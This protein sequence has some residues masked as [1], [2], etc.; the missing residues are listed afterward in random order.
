MKD[1]PAYLLKNGFVDKSIQRAVSC[2]T[3]YD[4]WLTERNIA[5]AEANYSDLLN[6]I[7]HMQQIGKSKSTINENLRYI[8]VYYN[9]L[10]IPNIA[11]DVK[12]IG[13][14]KQQVPLLK[15]EEMDKIYQNFEPRKTL[16]YQYSDKIMLGLMI[17]Q[18]ADERDLYNLE[19]NHLKLNE[20]KIYMP[21]GRKRKVARWLNLEAHQILALNEFINNYR[22]T[23]KPEHTEESEKL[24]KPQADNFYRI[25]EQMKLLSKQ[26]QEQAK[27]LEI[28]FI[29]FSQ[30]RYSRITL[31][32]RQHGLRKAQYMEGFR[33]VET[34]ERH[35]NF[36]VEDLKEH[37]LKCHPLK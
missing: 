29:R 37:V 2:A 25:H 4:K 12:L 7:G 16:Y 28:S 6:Y 21:S 18:G 35:Q 3:Y 1:Y 32:I 14:Q 20:G 5:I 30:L 22:K 27:Q 11:F 17:Y 10:Q 36:D 26:V 8:R 33:R 23:Y 31:W 19:L 15:A 34:A 13:E 9:Y 24:F